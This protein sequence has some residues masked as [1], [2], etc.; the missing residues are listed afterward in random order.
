LSEGSGPCWLALLGLVVGLA[1]PSG[2]TEARAQDPAPSISGGNSKNAMLARS[3]R[4]DFDGTR[5]TNAR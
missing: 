3:L 2:L 5:G 1:T 4:I